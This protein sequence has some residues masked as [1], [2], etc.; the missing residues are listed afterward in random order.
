MPLTA[1][2]QSKIRCRQIEDSDIPA[3]VDLLKRGF[4]GRSGRYWQ[5]GFARQA[6]RTLPREFP[7]YGYLLESDGRPVGVIL[8]LFT[9][10][11]IGG[12]RETR[13][14]VSSWYVEPDFRSHASLLIWFALK[15][16]N[17]TY[18]NISPARHTWSTIEAQGFTRYCGGEF[19]ALPALSPGIPEARVERWDPARAEHRSIAEAGLLSAHANYGCLSLVCTTPDGIHP[20]IFERFRIRKGRV[21]LPC[22]RLIYCRDIADFV[23]CAGS[24]GRFLLKRRMFCVVLDA[25]GPIKGLVGTYRTAGGRKYFRGPDRPRLGDLTYTEFVLFGP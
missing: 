25:N 11:D 18:V 7:R 1:A 21:P 14:N 9:S 22:M 16:K 15:H 6:D 12:R 19:F 4:P 20:F 23:R 3:V 5:R 24:V 8:L 10:I 2:P 13:C 17:V